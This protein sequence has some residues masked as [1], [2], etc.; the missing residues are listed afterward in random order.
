MTNDGS[1]EPDD[2]GGSISAI[3]PDVCLTL[4]AGATVGRLAFLGHGGRIELLP[5]NFVAVDREI[6]F[7]TSPRG[8]L[9]ALT[10]TPTHVAFG[11]D[12][13]DSAFGQGWNVTVRGETEGVTD[14]ETIERA[15]AAG[16]AVPWAGG[17]R[18]LVIRIVVAEID[19]RR[20]SRV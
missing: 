6:Y 10:E 1:S 3:P 16:L 17:D 18:T 14:P 5:V 13:V 19:G 9:A 20:V 4:L 15:Q 11:V 8:P 2:G 7:R 12:H